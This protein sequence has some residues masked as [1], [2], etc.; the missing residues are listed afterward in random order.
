MAAPAA[1]VTPMGDGAISASWA[2]QKS[3]QLRI[4]GLLLKHDE[5]FKDADVTSFQALSEVSLSGSLSQD[6]CAPMNVYENNSRHRPSSPDDMV[7]SVGTCEV[8][9]SHIGANNN[10][11]RLSNALNKNNQFFALSADLR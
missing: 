8:P 5:H 4:F 2:S 1:A 10:L 7:H 9:I 6:A 11:Y 3:N